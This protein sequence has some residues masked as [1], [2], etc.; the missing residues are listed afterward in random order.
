MKGITVKDH[1][2]ELE[3]DFEFFIVDFSK[4]LGKGYLRRRDLSTYKQ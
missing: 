4:T 2:D 1:R 3:E